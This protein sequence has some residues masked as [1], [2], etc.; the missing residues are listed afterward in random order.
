MRRAYDVAA[1]R[2]AEERAMAVVG[3]DAL[4]ASAAA[5]LARVCRGLLAAR[6][7]AIAS[8][9]VV[10]LVGSGNNGGDT[11]FAGAHLARRG[12]RVTAITTSA[13]SHEA[14]TAALCAAGG[15]VVA[16]ANDTDV[17][18]ATKL[19]RAADVVLDGIVGIGGRGALAEPAAT[20]VRAVRS[21]EAFRIAVDVPSGVDADTGAVPDPATAFCAD[22]TVTFGCLKPGLLVAPGRDFAGAV[23]LVDIGLNPYLPQVPLLRSLQAPDL[24]EYVRGPGPA[25]HKYSRGVIGVVAGSKQYPGAALLCVGGARRSG[26]GMVR[27]ADRGDGVAERVV[28]AYPDVVLQTEDPDADPRVSAWV[29]GPGLG[30]TK[31]DERWLLRVLGADVPVVLDADALRLYATSEDVRAKVGDRVGRGSLTVL[32]P[33]TGEF[34][35]IFG[36]IGDQGRVAAARAAAER[37]GCIVVLKGSGTLVAA[38]KG[39]SYVDPVAAHELATAGSGDVLAGLLGGFLAHRAARQMTSETARAIAAAVFVH[40][41]TAKVAAGEGRPVVATDL[42][43]AV[44][45]AIATLRGSR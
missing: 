21:G 39:A 34:A 11:L 37:S 3:P 25:D 22:L 28:T 29:V 16:A 23:E 18:A 27:F 5:G 33:H 1:V 40:G 14:G 6:G 19:L 9:T 43:D 8:S 13:T 32:T 17:G 41:L 31:A 10:L 24:A 44:G 20:L 36:A 38:R 15:R 26:V 45:P 7:G 12:A 42:L 30:H 35:A 2:A 4:M